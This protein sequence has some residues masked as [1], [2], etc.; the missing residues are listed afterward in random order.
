MALNL[1]KI[2]W[3]NYNEK[4]VQG[5]FIKVDVNFPE[6][7]HKLQND[8]PL[9]PETVKIEKFEKLVANLQ[10]KT[11]YVLQIRNLKQA[12]N[13]EIFLRKVHRVT[14]FN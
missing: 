11:E 5:Y 4:S 7:L 9:L 12:L 2:S 13:L 8:L 3:K 6:K 1:M 14:K 10:D